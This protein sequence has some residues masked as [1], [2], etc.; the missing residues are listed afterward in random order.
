M[1]GPFVTDEEV[2]TVVSHLKEQGEPEYLTEVTEESEEGGDGFSGNMN[3]GDELYDKA[4]DLVLREQ[5]AS[6]SFIQRHMK[7]GYNRAAT[8]VEKMEKEGLISSADHVGRRQIL[9]P[10]RGEA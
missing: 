4:V 10:K 1:H 6:I 5:K 9:G 3:S 7:I 2:E 8:L